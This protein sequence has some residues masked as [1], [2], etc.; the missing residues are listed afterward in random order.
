MA[1]AIKAKSRASAGHGKTNGAAAHP[2]LSAGVQS[3]L[4]GAKKNLIDGKWIPAAS[5]ETFPVFNPATGD[6]I[7]QCASGGAEDIQRAVTAARRAF[8][9]GPWRRMTPSER[10]RLI[11]RIGNLIL[12]HAD[13]LAEQIGR[14][15]V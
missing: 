13:E 8:E 6:V 15:H 7:A 9:S 10:G 2:P 3:F 4:R 14:A 5:G 1:T 11:W 12:E